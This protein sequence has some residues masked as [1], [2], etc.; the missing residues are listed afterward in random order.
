MAWD[1]QLNDGRS[2]MMSYTCKILRFLAALI[3][4]GQ[5][6]RAQPFVHPGGLHTLAD[7]ERMKTNVLAGNHPWIDDWSELISDPQAQIHYRTHVQANM[8]A[9]RQN[10]DLDAHAAYL[11]ALRWYISGDDTFAN[12][13]T[14][15]LTT[16][17]LAVNQR[18]SGTDIPGLSGIPIFDF[19]LAGEVLRAYP[20]WRMEHF[21]AFT[22]MM[23]QYLYPVC[24]DFLDR[25]NE[26]CISRYWA[27]WDACN[28]GAILAIGVL[29]DDTNKFNEAIAYFKGGAGNGAISNA[30]YFVHPDGLGQWQESG[31]DQEHTQLG[32]GVFGAMCEVAWNQGVDLFGYANNRLLAGAEYVA[33]CNLSEPVPFKV[34]NNCDD[35]KQFYVSNLGLGR[36]DDRPV[37]ELIYNHY[38]VRRGLSAP[39]VQKM[40][41]LVRP[42]PGSV[43]HFGYGTLAFTLNSTV[44]P[45]RPPLA[46][47]PTNLTASAGLER[48]ILKWSPSSGDAAQGYRIQRATN[49]NGPF[50]TIRAWANNTFP[51]YEDVGVSNGMTYYYAVAAINQAGTNQNSAPVSATPSAPGPLPPGWAQKDIGS[52]SSAGIASYAKVG[53]NTF[54]IGGD[55]ADIGGKADSFSFACTS[56]TNDFSFTARVLVN[57]SIKVGLMM[58]EDLDADSRAVAITVGETG[59]R[60][61]RFR[62]RSSVGARM[63]AQ[64]GNDYSY[65]PV[66]YRLQRNGNVFTAWQSADGVTWFKVGSS[67]VPM[68]AKYFA[69]FAVVGS[70]ATFDNVTLAGI[71]AAP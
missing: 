1:Q 2:T 33:R 19:A 22:N 5:V 31:R 6:L 35:V 57:G 8:G 3:L 68:K 54:V 20:G 50:T 69:G 64:S 65:V 47:T 29:C 27:N 63:T 58:R 51:E 24:H 49:V 18:P 45:Y 56:V 53:N 40:A 43:D 16:W 41:Q 55:G 36:V 61:T 28:M 71:S 34:Y 42:E 11:C 26:A 32:I 37:W 62:T 14:N 12:K 70:T 44:S 66:W 59:G 38:V 10:A 9:S 60:E 23:T 21:G 46:P 25:H 67:I 39:N 52:V 17:A 48:V 13:A 30:V 15:I 4:C 7:F